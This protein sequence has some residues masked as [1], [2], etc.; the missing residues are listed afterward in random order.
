MGSRRDSF[1]R[2]LAQCA[3]EGRGCPEFAGFFRGL[4][5]YPARRCLMAS[6]S[7]PGGDVLA[8]SQFRVRVGQPVHRCG[9]AHDLQGLLEPL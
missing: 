3:A 9:I 8:A 4:P 1:R 2:I 5:A 6:A 7:S